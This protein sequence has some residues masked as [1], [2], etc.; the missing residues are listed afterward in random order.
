MKNLLTIAVLAAM[1]VSC[2]PTPEPDPPVRF[3]LEE[4]AAKYPADLGS[5]VI[6]VS[7]YPEAQQANY[8]VFRL[9]CAQCHTLARAI[10]HP[11]A[12]R[13]DWE[14]LIERMHGKTVLHGW[15]TDFAKSDAKRVISFLE[16]DSKYR[17][18]ERKDT[19]DHS[20]RELKTFYDE[21]DA[22]RT[23]YNTAVD[24]AKAAARGTANQ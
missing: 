12:T 20:Q 16:Y 14:R 19:F 17:K 1:T 11:T 7:K 24:K 4:L 3:T 13:K 5:D 10:N 6:D 15:W 2:R 22:E 8:R 18:I 9:V 21:V 23:R